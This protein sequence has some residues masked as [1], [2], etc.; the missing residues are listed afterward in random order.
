MKKPKKPAIKVPTTT[1]S[2]IRRE[3]AQIEYEQKL[4]KSLV[5]DVLGMIT[6]LRGRIR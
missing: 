6:V 4:L 2:D 1:V 5:A 3:L